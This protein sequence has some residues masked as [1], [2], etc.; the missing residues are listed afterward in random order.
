MKKV[1][2][3]FNIDPNIFGFINKQNTEAFAFN[4]NRN[5]QKIFMVDSDYNVIESGNN[6]RVSAPFDPRLELQIS[7]YIESNWHTNKIK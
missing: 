1:E 7:E 6:Y 2:I 3:T 4:L 5:I